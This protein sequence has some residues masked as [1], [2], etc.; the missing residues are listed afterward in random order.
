MLKATTYADFFWFLSKSLF[1]SKKYGTSDRE[2]LT[3]ER[4]LE[5]GRHLPEGASFQVT[6]YTDC[7]NL[8]YLQSMYHLSPQSPRP[9]VGN[10]VP[11]VR[12][13]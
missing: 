13:I 11:C 7:K 2:L 5:D 1:P 12:T 8:F 10:D 6:I 9:D 3:L 4:V